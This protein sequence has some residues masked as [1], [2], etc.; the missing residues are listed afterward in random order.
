MGDKEKFMERDTYDQGIAAMREEIDQ[1]VVTV[2]Y[3]E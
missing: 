1:S 2:P 3:K